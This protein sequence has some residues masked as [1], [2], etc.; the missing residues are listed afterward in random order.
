[1]GMLLIFVLLF[2][3]MIFYGTVR[4]QW[5]ASLRLSEDLLVKIE[6]R[7]CVAYLV[8]ITPYSFLK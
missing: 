3:K 5:T 2:K 1:V 7:V 4:S 8:D 6:D